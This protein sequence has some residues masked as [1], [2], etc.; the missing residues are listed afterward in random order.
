MTKEKRLILI[1]LIIIAAILIYCWAT[2]ITTEIGSTWR[3]YLGLVLFLLIAICF[4]R[5]IIITTVATGIYLIL[6][7]FN[8]LA[9]TPAISTFS[10]GVGP[11]STPDMQG[12]SLGL[13]ILYFILNMD[14]LIDIYLDYKESK[15]KLKLN[16]NKMN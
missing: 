9:L 11:V 4:F 5:N 10:F 1:P 12:L 7:T 13:F 6:S 3:H 16:Q 8:L 2:F 15:Q 14:S